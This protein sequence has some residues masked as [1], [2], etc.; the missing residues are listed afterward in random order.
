MKK[1]ILILGW[2]GAL[3]LLV[4]ALSLGVYTIMNQ[5]ILD[6][7][8]KEIAEDIVESIPKNITEELGQTLKSVQDKP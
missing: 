8:K 4:G 7:E 1:L 5:S 6:Q 3:L 2:P